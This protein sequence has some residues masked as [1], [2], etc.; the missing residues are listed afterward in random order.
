DFLLEP[1][2]LLH[3]QLA[4]AGI[5]HEYEEFGGTHDWPYWNEHLAD[6]LRFFARH[7]Q[8]L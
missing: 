5:I 3:Q 1:N 4:E 8:P 7:L 2:R 6:S